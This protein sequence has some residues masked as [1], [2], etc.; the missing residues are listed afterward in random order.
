MSRVFWKR[1]FNGSFGVRFILL[2]F[3]YT[4]K[5]NFKHTYSL[6]TFLLPE[7]DLSQWFTVFKIYFLHWLSKPSNGVS[8]FLPLNMVLNVNTVHSNAH[9]VF[10]EKRNSTFILYSLFCDLSISSLLFLLC[11]KSF[12][13]S[14][15]FDL[16]L[17]R[18][19]ECILPSPPLASEEQSIQI[20]DLFLGDLNKVEWQSLL[21]S[22]A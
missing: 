7:L 19:W 1:Q 15:S 12:S 13:E 16:S 10:A 3:T 17:E 20:D 5:P 11:F 9:F 14:V 18:W 21:L 22:D 2:M 4:H 6:A 8:L